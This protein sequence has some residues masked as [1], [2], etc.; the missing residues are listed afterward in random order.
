MQISKV[1]LHDRCGGASGDGSSTCTFIYGLIKQ[2]GRKTDAL[3]AALSRTASLR[4]QNVVG[5]L[6]M[7]RT[8]EIQA[9]TE[10]RTIGV[11]VWPPYQYRPLMDDEIRL[12]R[13][14]PGQHNETLCAQIIHRH[15]EGIEPGPLVSIA[16]LNETLPDGWRSFRTP[17]R[18]LVYKNT[19]SNGH[20]RYDHPL[21]EGLTGTI[22]DALAAEVNHIKSTSITQGDDMFEAL[23][24]AW[25]DPASQDI[26]CVNNPNN[27]NGASQ[28]P[29]TS[30]LSSALRHLRY[31]NKNRVL[32]V[33]AICINQND[34]IERNAQVLRSADIYSFAD[35]VVVWIGEES[36]DSG[37]AMRTVQQLGE[38]V[39]ITQD[40][41]LMS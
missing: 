7:Y 21:A 14:L 29:I 12:I 22:R 17:E 30:N 13:L 39:E 6:V 40:S 38:G 37:L 3:T 34:T 24:Y 15:F 11:Q 28:L 1:E 19:K 23:S 36:E 31:E 16:D 25:G 8:I 5:S 32:W 10:Y 18:R 9:S 20:H 4:T 35:R 27:I 33:D 41:F 2:L 26:L